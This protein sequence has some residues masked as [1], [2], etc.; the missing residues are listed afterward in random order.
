[1]VSLLLKDLIS[2]FY[3]NR[4][5]DVS[6]FSR[7][8]LI[9]SFLYTCQDNAFK[10]NRETYIYCKSIELEKITGANWNQIGPLV[11]TLSSYKVS[12]RQENLLSIWRYTGAVSRW[13]YVVNKYVE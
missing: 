2:N 8:F 9:R 13:R 3:Y 12:A 6:T 1:M 11:E 5:N 4:E 7:M 10:E